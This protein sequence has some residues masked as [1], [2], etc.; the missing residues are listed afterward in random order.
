MAM[1]LPRLDRYVLRQLLLALVAVTT[2]LVALIWL[3]QSLRFVEL[4]V[5]RGLS[6]R[7]FL[8]LTSL[9]IPGFVAVILPITTFVVVQSVYQRLAGDREL[10]VMRSAGLSQ[11]AL[12]RPA[13]L[14]A[15]V[16]AGCCFILNIWVVP[17]SS[18]AF[19]EY[20]FEIRNRVAAFLLQEGVFT[21]I[22]DKLTVYVRSRDPDGML[23]G[24]LVEDDRQDAN[25][26][27]ILAERGRLLETRGA[28]QVLLFN[29]SRQEIDRKTG[30]LD[31]LTIDQDTL[32]LESANKSDEQRYRDVNEMSLYE[33]THPDPGTVMAR[34][35][36]KLLVEAHRRLTQPFT[37]ISFALVALVSVLTGGFRRHGNILRPMAA[38]GAVVLLLA[39][40]LAVSSLA[41]RRPALVPLIWLHAIAPGAV[42]AW[43]LFVPTGAERGFRRLRPALGG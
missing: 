37:A 3:T 25:R 4:V 9:L 21:P 36:G 20:Q 39:L 32:D 12:A 18:R 38:V 14:A 43:V 35:Y 6:L 29:G 16:A 8:E 30:R 41:T 7:V 28:P 33:L 13:L 10:T 11:Y 24:I 40:G 31:V 17:A 23:R 22:S 5:N 15:A 19:R 42:A 2:A 1:L 27:T 26:A 34:D